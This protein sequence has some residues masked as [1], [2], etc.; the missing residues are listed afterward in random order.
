MTRVIS[1]PA[2]FLL[3]A[4]VAVV[5]VCSGIADGSVQL[6]G[7]VIFGWIGYLAY[8]LPRIR[9]NYGT[10]WSTV[11]LVVLL[12]LGSHNLCGWIYRAMADGVGEAGPR[13]WRARWTLGLLAAVLVS[14]AA[15]TSAVAVVHQVTYLSRSGQ[16]IWGGGEPMQ[17]IRCASQVRQ[18]LGALTRYAE[19]HD[20]R[21]PENLADL[22]GTDD[23]DPRTLVCP[24]FVSLRPKDDGATGTDQLATSFI[25]IGAGLRQPVGE[26]AILIL[27]PPGHHGRD[28]SNVGYGDGHVEWLRADQFGEELSSQHAA[29]GTVHTNGEPEASSLPLSR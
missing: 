4:G 17:A 24:T 23:F 21:F 18:V 11:V 28:G 14:F 1:K 22:V 16:A 7:H 6:L 8:V 19:A 12:G 9:L 29:R 26:R 2:L 15:G 13:R 27:E 10:L 5:L 25:Y 20:G 3:L